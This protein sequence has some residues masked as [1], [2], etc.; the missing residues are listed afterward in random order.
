MGAYR[1]W[2]K[3][4]NTPI[5]DLLVRDPEETGDHVKVGRKILCEHA[6]DS[7][8]R[9]SGTPSKVEPLLLLEFEKGKVIHHSPSLEKRREFCMQRV[10]QLRDDYLRYTN[11][12]P[13]KVSVSESL[14]EL[15]Q[16]LWRREV[17]VV[18]YH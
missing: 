5:L 8:K 9:C 1:L 16:K 7:T 13:Y 18:D 3:S 17:P 10:A 14:R 11:P 15:T 6:F 12:T 4:T 2:A